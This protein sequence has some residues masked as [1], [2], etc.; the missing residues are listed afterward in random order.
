MILYRKMPNEIIIAGIVVLYNPEVNVLDNISTYLPSLERLYIIDNSEKM[1]SFNYSSLEP[2]KVKYYY[3]G[4]NI[5]V[6]AAL[7]KGIMSAIEDDYDYCILFDQDTYV[8]ANMMNYVKNYLKL[9][10]SDEVGIYSAVP[11]YTREEDID[12]RKNE[13][14]DV[15]ITSGSI[16]SLKIYK[17]VGPFINKLFIDY[18]DFEYCLRLRREGFRIAQMKEALIYHRLGNLEKKIFLFKWIFITN[19]SPARYYYRTRN[20]FYVYRQY[21]LTFPLFVLK[22]L[23]IFINELLKILFFESNR[24]KKFNMIRK[25]FLDFMLGNY[26]KLSE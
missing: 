11:H 20:R 16:I 15:A 25:G 10:E 21:F 17:I 22:D 26:G 7:N 1:N 18:V 3:C 13:F 23:I 2:S 8:E 4:G 14:L 6:A 5:G 9:R 24:K 19:H 12:K